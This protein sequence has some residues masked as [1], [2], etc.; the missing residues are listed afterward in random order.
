MT[1]GEKERV[2]GVLDNP[3][4]KVPDTVRAQSA[5][6]MDGRESDGVGD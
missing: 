2:W 4:L 5:C 3:W 1:G 6:M